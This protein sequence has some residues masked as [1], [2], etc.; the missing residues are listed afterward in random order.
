MDAKPIFEITKQ[1]VYASLQDTSRIGYGSIG[2]PFSGP[3]D[4]MSH[5][6]VNHKLENKNHSPTLEIYGSGLELIVLSDVKIRIAGAE[7]EF[8]VNG[9]ITNTSKTLKIKKASVLTFG[10]LSKGIW[11]YLGIKGGFSSTSILGSV[12]PLKGSPINSFKRGN[13]IYRNENEFN[14]ESKLLKPEKTRIDYSE[15]I[16]ITPGPEYDVLDEKSKALLINSSFQICNESNRMGYRMKGP[17]LSKH[18]EPDILTSAVLPGTVQLL[19]SG[20]LIVLM[21]DCQ[22][23]GGYPRVLQIEK[24]SINQLAQRPPLSEINFSF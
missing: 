1:G 7:I 22:T 4:E 20:Q 13:I 24:M 6:F 17:K 10:K 23:T 16:K 21:K 9:V 19:T 11:T 15:R 5:S 18:K 12:S 8:K 2:V 14:Q 3:M